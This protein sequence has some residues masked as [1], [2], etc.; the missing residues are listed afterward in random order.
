MKIWTIYVSPD[1]V[2]V[3]TKN[4]V[5]LENIEEKEIG[6][7]LLQDWQPIELITYEEGEHRDVLTFR[8]GSFAIIVHHSVKEKIQTLIANEAEFL[9]LHYQNQDYYLIN[10]TN[11]LDCIDYEQSVPDN[12][13][14]FDE[15]VLLPDKVHN[16]P[17]FKTVNTKHNLGD[18]PIVSVT[19]Y[20]SDELKE[21]IEQAEIKGIYFRLAWT[22]STE[23][24]VEHNPRI[25]A[26]S[27]KDLEAHIEQHYGRITGCIPGA[28]NDAG[29]AEIYLA[30]PGSHLPFQTLVTYGNS[31][32]RG[33]IPAG[34]D[35]GYV[36]LVVHLPPDAQLTEQNWEQSPYAWV[37][38]M[39]R[40]FGSEIMQRGYWIGQWLV[41]PHQNEDDLS[42]SYREMFSLNGL[43]AHTTLIPYDTTTDYCGVMVVPPYPGSAEAFKMTYRDEGVAD[44][45]EWPIYFQTLLP[46]YAEEIQYYFSNGQEKTVEKLLSGGIDALFDLRRQR[47]V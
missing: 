38:R 7:P 34:H 41:Y 35:T 8:G 31:F 4:P 40:H 20:V 27:R 25:R 45:E 32:W 13:G 5:D 12:Y 42:D 9:E 39:L 28:S 37:V 47:L 24:I 3:D 23:P 19:T 33:M 29:D 11:V 16:Q 18:F 1:C 30:A 10:V 46:L 15:E 14:G 22:D 44:P 26:T 17:I 36:E 6:K 43:P 2:K 21:A